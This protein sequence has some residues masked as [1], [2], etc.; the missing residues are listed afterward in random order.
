[1]KNVLVLGAGLMA[2]PL[3]EYLSKDESV[4]VR[5]IDINRAKAEAVC[6]D[7]PNCAPEALDI[8]D[9]NSLAAHV[10]QARVAVS[11]LPWPLHPRVAEAC[12]EKGTH[13]VTTSYVKPEMKALDQAAKN[14]NLLFLNEIGADPGID[15]MSTARM[16]R[17]VK[18]EGGQVAQYRAYGTS[19]PSPA[20]NTN[21]LGYK[22]SWSPEGFFLAST[23]PGRYLEDGHVRE[24]AEKDLFSHYRFVEIPDVGI[25]EAFV[26]RDALPY[27]DLYDISSASCM[28][29][30]TLRYPGSCETWQLFKKLGLFDKETIWDFSMISPRELVARLAGCGSGDLKACLCRLLGIPALFRVYPQAQMAGPV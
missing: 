8:N 26:N 28:Y 30:G 25:F 10:G 9:K 29:R 24:V 22:F 14:K 12:V 27:M 18:S 2:R 21:P 11:L 15:H 4:Q 1:M 6:G 13:L 7:R 19:L 3:V 16:V 23:A 17:E 5:V 20:S